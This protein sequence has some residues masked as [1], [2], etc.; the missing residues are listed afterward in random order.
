[1]AEKVISLDAAG[2]ASSILYFRKENKHLLHGDAILNARLVILRLLL[3]EQEP[4][5]VREVIEELNAL[6]DKG[7]TTVIIPLKTGTIE[8]SEIPLDRV[9]R[10]VRTSHDLNQPLP[11]LMRTLQ[12]LLRV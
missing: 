8:D 2:Q 10:E 3:L 5:K 6:K 7:I 1:M 11:Q 4:S 9:I 12:Q